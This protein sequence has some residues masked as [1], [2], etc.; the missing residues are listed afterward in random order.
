[1]ILRKVWDMARKLETTHIFLVVTRDGRDA[2]D[3]KALLHEN[4]AK[5]Q[6]NSKTVCTVV[7]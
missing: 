1:M 2:I 6:P 7:S 3:G 5:L 4:T